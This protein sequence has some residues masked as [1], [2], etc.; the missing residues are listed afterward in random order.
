VVRQDVPCPDKPWEG[1]IAARTLSGTEVAQTRSDA[2]GRFDLA[3]A[4]GNYVVVTIT[5]GGIMPHPAEAQVT[6][7]AG[8]VVYLELMLDSGI[9]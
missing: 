7:V 1:V 2:D 3:L 6:V 5:N 4:T 8:S 9:R